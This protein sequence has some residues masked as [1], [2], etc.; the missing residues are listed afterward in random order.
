MQSKFLVFKNI[1]NLGIQDKEDDLKV[2]VKSTA[3]RFG[4]STK[5]WITGFGIAC[6]GGLALSG[7]N[8]EIGISL[9][10]HSIVSVFVTV[11]IVSTFWFICVKQAGRIMHL[12]QLHLDT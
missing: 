2:G 5:E 7:F 6:L 8:A 11:S 12:W 4:D 3:L 9:L 10:R 1:S